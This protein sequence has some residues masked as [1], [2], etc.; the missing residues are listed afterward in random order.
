[1]LTPCYCASA[2][3]QPSHF[4]FP[5]AFTPLSV[6][7][8]SLGPCP[9]TLVP[10]RS[11]TLRCSVGAQKAQLLIPISHV[12]AVR[13]AHVCHLCCC[14]CGCD[15]RQG[16]ACV[17]PQAHGRE[18]DFSRPTR[19]VL[20]HEERHRRRGGCGA[21]ASHR[22][23]VTHTHT[24]AHGSRAYTRSFGG[25]SLTCVC[26]AISCVGVMQPAVAAPRGLAPVR[27]PRCQVHR[28]RGHHA[29]RGSL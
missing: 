12:H 10:C 4:V 18:G 3:H 29:Q 21:Q 13:E 24:P 7:H 19:M 15:N 22:H 14:R 2:A 11:S 20:Q 5:A 9:R 17:L 23:I 25:S 27:D 28:R 1:M 6:L 16:A 8:S 26:F